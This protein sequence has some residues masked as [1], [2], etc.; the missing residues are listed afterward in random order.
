MLG[1]VLSRRNFREADQIISLYTLEQG[2]V[3]VLARGVKKIT[4]KN[5]AHLEP[6]SYIDAEIIPGKELPHL[7]AVQSLEYFS[8]IRQDLQ[9]SLVA[10]FVVNFLNKILHDGEKDERLFTVTL[11]FIKYLNQESTVCNLEL[12]DGYIVKLLHC[13]GY[14]IQIIKANP[15]HE[16]IYNFLVNQLERKIGDWKKL[17]LA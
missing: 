10:S 1:L 5:S 17:F 11:D 13:L 12:I 14:D 2:K 15:D 16:F 6:F 9:K 3:E 7:G 4:S 8:H